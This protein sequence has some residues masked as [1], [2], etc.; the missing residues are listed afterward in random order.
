ML[1]IKDASLCDLPLLTEG[2]AQCFQDPWG[3]S[4]IRSHLESTT[5]L[6]LIA[7]D[8]EGACLGHLF[9]LSLPPEGELLRIAVR[10]EARKRGIGQALMERFLYKCRET[11]LSVLFLE[12]RE[13]N[14]PAIRLYEKNGFLPMGRRRRYYQAP[15]EDALL[16]RREEAKGGEA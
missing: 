14:L 13:S 3:E 15:V 10:K 4:A 9:A 16:L 2:E 6:S 12:V 5:S 7:L 11:G 1:L 8:E